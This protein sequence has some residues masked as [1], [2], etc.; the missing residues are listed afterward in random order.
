VQKNEKWQLGE[1][2]K[3][4]SLN[5]CSPFCSEII[6]EADPRLILLH[7]LYTVK[8]FS[9]RCPEWDISENA[10]NKDIHGLVREYNGR[11]FILSKHLRSLCVKKGQGAW[12]NLIDAKL[13][14]L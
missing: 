6:D 5:L 10:E 1:A 9:E 7:G 4:K 11:T 14:K 13:E 8:F 3:Q 2:E 12:K